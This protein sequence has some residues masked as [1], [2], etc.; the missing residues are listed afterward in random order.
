VLEFTR[1][2]TWFAAAAAMVGLLAGLSTI[3]TGVN[4]A[5][6]FLCARQIAVLSCPSAVPSH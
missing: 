6:I 2:Q 1:L 5:S 4:N 3:A